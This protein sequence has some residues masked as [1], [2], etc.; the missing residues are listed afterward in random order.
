MTKTRTCP[1]L[2]ADWLNAWLAA[3]GACVLVPQLRLSWTD[4]P[5]PL[6]VLHHRHDPGAALAAAWP[7][8]ERLQLMPISRDHPQGVLETR[9]QQ[10]KE[11]LG[12]F[13]ARAKL[14][15]TSPDHWTMS[16]TATDLSVD[17]DQF[18]G[19]APFDPKAPG[20][21]KWLHH[22][23]LKLHQLVDQPHQQLV[24]TLEGTAGPWGD[25]GLGFDGRRFGGP[26]DASAE[27]RTNPV[28]ELLAF[29]GLAL[30]PVRGSGAVGRRAQPRQRGWT[31]QSRR[32]TFRYP[33]W[34]FPLSSAGIDA[35]LDVWDQPSRGH[36]EL[37][38][39]TSSWQTVEYL[40]K[41]G[42]TATVAYVTVRG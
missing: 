41:A 2:P 21:T 6:A 9:G 17:E 29:F 35:L 38:G 15:R 28:I 20:T 22:R 26:A 4:D 31:A 39:V 37:L 10:R 11:R 5:V 40:P 1:G 16:S 12:A 14:A 3:V 13:I 8:Q 27:K 18:V 30:F 32:Q 34:N 36:D 19:R 42:E 23:L 7:D 33:T 25:N 24:E